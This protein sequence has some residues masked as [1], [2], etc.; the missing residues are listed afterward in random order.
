MVYDLVEIYIILDSLF[1]SGAIYIYTVGTYPEKRVYKFSGFIRSTSV[2]I[3][4]R[5]QS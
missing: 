5:Y 3:Y 2:T 4:F 1:T